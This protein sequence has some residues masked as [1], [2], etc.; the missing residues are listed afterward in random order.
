MPQRNVIAD[1]TPDRFAA[2]WR[3][4]PAGPEDDFHRPPTDDPATGR[5]IV[6]LVRPRDLVG[7][8]VAITGCDLVGGDGL[9]TS[10]VCRADQPGMLQVDYGYQHAHEFARYEQP[11]DSPALVADPLGGRPQ[12]DTVPPDSDAALPVPVGYRP[13]RATRLVFEIPAGAE[14]E[15]S[16]EGILGQ[17]SQLAPLL[18]PLGAPGGSAPAPYDPPGEAVIRGPFLELAEG[19]VGRLTSAGLVVSKAS[20]AQRREGLLGAALTVGEANLVAERSRS[21]RIELQR[22]TPVV[23]R[24]VDL[25]AV[26][27]GLGG[28]FPRPRDPVRARGRFSEP[29]T[30]TE[31]AIEAPF[32]LV[33]SP[34]QEARWAHAV[35]PVTAEDTASHVELWHSRL[36]NEGGKGDV[37]D[38]L[39]QSRR[40]V[41]AV[42]ARDRDDLVPV[43]WRDPQADQPPGPLSTPTATPTS[44]SDDPFRGS[45]NRADRHRIVRQSSE[46]WLGIGRRAITPVPIA[47]RAL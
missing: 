10:V 29:P 35:A 13:A 12:P 31:T 11:Q 40:V 27:G 46:T 36:A 3:L 47:A 5:I 23:A 44:A 34:T 30:L 18:H 43:D 8:T 16:T 39:N 14:F 9:A 22:A 7:L 24:G 32:R 28:L 6:D 33:L 45:L 20:A 1:L 21:A 42:W 37:P 26:V 25:G 38:E 19:V 4:L 15:F 17:L 2:G 41:R